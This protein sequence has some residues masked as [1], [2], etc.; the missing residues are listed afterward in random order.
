VRDC[1]PGDVVV[2]CASLAILSI[3]ADYSFI[4]LPSFFICV[5]SVIIVTRLAVR[6]RA[7]SVIFHQVCLSIANLVNTC[8]PYR[9]EG[10]S[11]AQGPA[12][13]CVYRICRDLTRFAERGH[14]SNPV[15]LL[16]PRE[17]PAY[18]PSVFKGAP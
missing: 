6:S 8:A 14:G 18:P 4:M 7:S 15:Q 9:R 16:S 10:S 2:R 11:P 13:V 17:P 12:R 1:L 5:C 3:D